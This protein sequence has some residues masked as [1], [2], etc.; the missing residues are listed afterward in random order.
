MQYGI[1]TTPMNFHFVTLKSI[2][3]FYVLTPLPMYYSRTSCTG[4]LKNTGSLDYTGLSNVD[5]FYYTIS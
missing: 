5:T 1:G 2:A 4:H 3:L